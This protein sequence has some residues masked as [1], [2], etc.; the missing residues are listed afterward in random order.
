M[1]KILLL[2]VMILLLT[3][4]VAIAGTPTS[5]LLSLQGIVTD[6]DDNPISGDLNITIYN[7]TQ[8]WVWNSTFIGAIQDGIFDLLLEG[9]TPL[10]L[11]NTQLHYLDMEVME[12]GLEFQKVIDKQRFYPG[13]G[14]HL[15]Q[16]EYKQPKVFTMR[17]GTFVKVPE[18]YWSLVDSFDFYAEKD[19]DILVIYSIVTSPGNTWYNFYVDNQS[20]GFSDNV[21][22]PVDYPP[23]NRGYNMGGYNSIHI[24]SNV[25]TGNH[26]LEIWHRGPWGTPAYSRERELS[27]IVYPK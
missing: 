6:I 20:I 2:P 18:H 16:V 12:T 10:N 1:K 21:Y 15:P 24:M 27:V 19:S 25:T 22:P 11:D 14:Q 7:S 5:H 4:S 8:D 13:S 23:E 26:T 17:Q 9:T 3:L